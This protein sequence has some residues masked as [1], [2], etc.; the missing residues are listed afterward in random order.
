MIL[1]SYQAVLGYIHSS[2]DSF[3]RLM[4]VP[5]EYAVLP[6]QVL[7][8]RLWGIQPL[9]LKVEESDTGLTVENR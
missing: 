9:S 3:D 5:P 7:H 4:K 2:W 8:C 6:S 1:Y